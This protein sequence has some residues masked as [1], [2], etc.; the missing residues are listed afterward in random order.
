MTTLPKLLLTT[1]FQLLVLCH[2]ICMNTARS[3][4]ST[5]EHKHNTYHHQHYARDS[6]TGNTALHTIHPT[7]LVVEEPDHDYHNDDDDKIHI[8][9]ATDEHILSLT[10]IS[11]TSIIHHATNLSNI[12][13][14]FVLIN[15][16]YSTI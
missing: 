14:Y 3:T 11:V 2:I 4:T 15:A 9:Y 12:H 5:T 13:I 6:P 8:V 10:L 1:L 16:R 7:S